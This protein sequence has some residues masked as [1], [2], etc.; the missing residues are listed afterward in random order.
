MTDNAKNLL[1][2]IIQHPDCQNGLRFLRNSIPEGR[3]EELVLAYRELLQLGYIEETG[4]AIG[5]S[6]LAVTPAGMDAANEE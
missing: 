2:E 4:K 3:W 5:V 1:L 6:F